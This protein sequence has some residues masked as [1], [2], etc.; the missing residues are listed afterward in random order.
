MHSCLSMNLFATFA[1]L[2]PGHPTLSTTFDYLKQRKKTA[3]KKDTNAQWFHCSWSILLKRVNIRVRG[4][5]LVFWVGTVRFLREHISFSNCDLK[6]V[7]FP[8]FQPLPTQNAVFFGKVPL[9]AWWLSSSSSQAEVEGKRTEA[10]EGANRGVEKRRC[11]GS[12][13]LQSYYMLLADILLY[14]Y[15]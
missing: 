15:M 3:E 2:L 10:A 4:F 13:I 7:E 1:F 12:S 11:S 8:D 6:L 9:V 14:I 5:H